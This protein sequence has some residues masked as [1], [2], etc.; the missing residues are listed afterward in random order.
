MPPTKRCL[1]VATVFRRGRRTWRISVP[2]VLRALNPC[3]SDD[4]LDLAEPWFRRADLGS[5]L[6][7]PPL[8]DGLERGLE[9]S[10]PTLDPFSEIRGDFSFR[11]EVPQAT[12]STSRGSVSIR[13][14]T[15]S[16]PRG[17]PR[18]VWRRSPRDR[19][20]QRVSRRAQGT[21]RSGPR[22]P[23]VRFGGSAASRG[24]CP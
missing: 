5:F 18:C 10:D 20:P 24:P 22:G 15:P 1:E 7:R 17:G 14:R 23:S 19:R 9:L 21:G 16:R 2:K 13:T 4:F 6:P 11:N 12:V 3:S 8:W